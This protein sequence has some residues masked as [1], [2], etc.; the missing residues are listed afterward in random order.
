MVTICPS[1]FPISTMVVTGED[2]I[3]GATESSD[4]ES[5]THGF[6]LSFADTPGATPSPAS[7]T[8]A[9]VSPAGW[10]YRRLQ[11][12]AAVGESGARSAAVPSLLS[13]RSFPVPATD[14]NP[15]LLRCRGRV[16]RQRAFAQSR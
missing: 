3:D 9:P 7:R 16:L 12:R 10:P 4:I 6:N 13:S 15:Y 8:L 2:I 1:C 11:V 14:A 5:M